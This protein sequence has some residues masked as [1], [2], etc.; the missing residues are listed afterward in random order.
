MK[1][2]MNKLNV[3]FVK[4][5]ILYL[6]YIFVINLCAMEGLDFSPYILPKGSSIRAKLDA[7]RRNG[8]QG[9][10]IVRSFGVSLRC[11]I[12]GIKKENDD[13]LNLLQ[14]DP[15]WQPFDSF[16]W[17][18]G[19]LATAQGATRFVVKGAN[20]GAGIKI[21]KPNDWILPPV[22]HSATQNLS[23]LRKAEEINRFLKEKGFTSIRTPQMW[24]YPITGN[25]SDLRKKGL[26]DQDVVIIEEMVNKKSEDLF[27]FPG[28]QEQCQ[29][30]AVEID[31]ETYNQLVAVAK[32]AQILDLHPKNFL[33][34]DQGR[35]VLIDI[36]DLL[37]PQREAVNRSNVLL[38]PW[39]RYKLNCVHDGSVEIGVGTTGVVNRDNAIK[40]QGY[41]LFLHG[42][43]TLLI[44][45]NIVEILGVTVATLTARW[46]SHV[47]KTNK[48]I[49]KCEKKIRHQIELQQVRDS[50]TSDDV[51]IEIAR[52]IVTEEVPKENRQKIFE[53]FATMTLAKIKGTCEG[54]IKILDVEYKGPEDAVK[55]S[56]CTINSIWRSDWSLPCKVARSVEKTMNS[57]RA[58]RQKLNGTLS[59]NLKQ[60]NPTTVF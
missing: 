35:I 49:K 1:I 47:A 28:T 45:K 32:K 33:V 31:Q 5:L 2:L 21:F 11:A 48:R 25:Y 4:M 23:R 12:E 38:R 27:S 9:I 36:E 22:I 51:Y 19:A 52:G 29:R 34:D 6:A 53:A 54:A 55:R 7:I 59:N 13:F 57:I 46:L 8:E 3:R 10:D 20:H 30:D 17:L 24:V 50:K 15:T 14:L 40:K 43:Y 16:H 18:V 42:F 44:A 26:T 39:K 56:H 60:A 41:K 37:E 58:M